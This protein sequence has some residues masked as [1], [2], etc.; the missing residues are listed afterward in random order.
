M[1]IF[2]NNIISVIHSAIRF[3]FLKV[4]N[5]KGVHVNPIQ[6]FSPNVVVEVNRGGQ[7]YIGE[8]V[9]VHS[10][11]KI[12]VRK[13][14]KLTIERGA[15]FNYGCIIVCQ[16]DITIGEGSELGPYVLVYDH[17]HDYKLGLK[18]DKYKTAPV[19]I[20]SNCWIGANTVILRGSEIGDNC[21]IGAGSV[22]K[23]IIPSNSV[24]IQE[25]EDTI[26]SIKD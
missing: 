3:I 22:I 5:F 15:K 12:K 9:R 16:E 19:K 10:G 18:E 26:V 21:V 7:L 4:V 24:V 14:G 6:R 2:F 23:E 20:G 11:S 13:G 25:R 8:K 17:D 1:R